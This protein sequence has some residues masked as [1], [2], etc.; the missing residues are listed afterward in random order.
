MPPECG[1]IGYVS[2]PHVY[3]FTFNDDSQTSH[4]YDCDGLPD[5]ADTHPGEAENLAKNLGCLSGLCD[6]FAGNPANVVTGN[7]YEEVLDLTI[8]TPGLP[9]EIRRSYNSQ[10]ITDGPLGY[11]WIHTYDLSI[12][13]VQETSPK[14]VIVWDSDGRAL[15]FTENSRT[16]EIIF[17][18]ESGVKDRLKQVIS[19]GEYFLRRKEGNLTYKFGSDGRLLEISD[20]SGNRLTFT[21]TGGLLTQVSNNFEKS[22]SIQYNNNRISS[23]TD[24]KGQSILYEYLNGDLTKV[25]YP[26]QNFIRYTYSNHRMTDKYDN[27]NNLIGHWVYDTWGRVITYYSHVK[28]GVPQERIDLTFE[29]GRT[30]VTRST[31]TTTYTTAVI[32]GINVV[33]QVEGCSTCGS[34]NKSFQY[35]NRLDLTHVTSTSDGQNYTTQYT[36]DNP[37]NSWEQVGEILQM[38]EAVGKPEQRTTSYS[39][40]HRTDDPF[41]LTQSTETIKSVV[42]PQQNKVI[43]T[44]YDNQ[45]NILSRQEAGYV[46]INGT[47]TQKTY[48]TSYQ[49]N[50]YG[51]LTEIN[52]PI[53]GNSDVTTFEYYGST[54]SIVNNRYQ[55]KAIVNALSQRTEFSNYDAN[56]NVGKITDPNGVETEYTYD[57]RN[58]I[59]TIENL[60][61]NALTEYSYD[62][63]G[64]LS[65]IV[66]PEGNQIDFT[67]N[68]ANKL[69]EIKDSL[70]NKIKYYYNVEGNR[71]REEIR[72]PQGT[73]KKQLDFT[74]DAYN[75]LKKIINP[76]SNYAEYTYDGRGNATSIKD[77]KSNTTGYE[78]DP[79]SRLKKMTQRGTVITDYG[80][81][82][83]DNPA[84]VTDPRNH[85]TQYVYD[86]F[87]RKNQDHFPGY[88][89]HK[90][91]I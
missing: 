73:L 23:I 2:I 74:Y 22:L 71:E 72:D 43:T 50:N 8:S 83:Q 32:N 61:T 30:L 39:Y 1:P 69:T 77:P 82:T 47:P 60:T 3:C 58:R 85:T 40:T 87:G 19:T 49:Y 66:L 78:Y 9:L 24:P 21:Y 68:L 81:D 36:Y 62:A 46:L 45:G 70:D 26:D 28:D 12:Q 25:T 17:A 88:R 6:M 41:L 75:R 31:G 10:V 34:V 79:L 27:N 84:S 56:G 14:R 16:T 38:K 48:T 91:R 18:G 37:P 59:K 7:K 35:S 29:L 65:S 11:G 63:R 5:S 4:D 64:N 13:V 86:D 53:P 44:A 54:E 33:Q 55:L 90:I 80:Y 15:Y 76:D 67:Y 51:Q 52:G 89:D 42:D 57:E 20:P